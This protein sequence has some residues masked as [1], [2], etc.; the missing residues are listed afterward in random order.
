VLLTRDAV[1]P[2]SGVP[3]TLALT[4]VIYLV[5]T[6]VCIMVPLGMGRRWRSTGD[7]RLMEDQATPYGPPAEREQEI[8]S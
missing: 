2:A 6:A 7:P 5:L 4:I 1:T 8:R 3:I